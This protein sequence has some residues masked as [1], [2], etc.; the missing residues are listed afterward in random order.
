MTTVAHLWRHPIKSH[1]R[2]ALE[3]VT[4]TAGESMPWDRHWAV[5]HEKSK[6][7]HTNPQWAMCRNFMIGVV[8]PK[9]A[10]IWAKLDEATGEITLRHSALDDITFCPDDP[11]DVARFLGWVAPLS[12]DASSKPTGLASAGRRGLTDSAYPSVSVMNLASHAAVSAR[13]GGALETER[14]RGNVWLDGLSP[15]EEME[16]TGR[17]IR[18]GDARLIVREPIRRCKHTMANPITGKRDADTL[19]VLENTFG[20][21]HFGMYC[22]VVGG[23]DIALGDTAEVL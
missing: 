17:E 7:D 21:Q 10:G 2:E 19:E 18:I 1:G 5:E 9:L 15:W 8:L 14:W 3:A 11:D 4:L 16:W 6:F 12:A 23:G 20:H 22:E 13:L